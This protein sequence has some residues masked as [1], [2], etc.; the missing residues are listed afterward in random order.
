MRRFLL[1]VIACVAG[2]ATQPNINAKRP[3]LSEPQIVSAM[4]VDQCHIVQAVVFV[5]EDGTL[6][7]LHTTKELTSAELLT[8]LANVPAGKVLGVSLPCPQESST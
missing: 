3:A 6:H 1:A 4:V 7:P 2:C 8:I 5:A